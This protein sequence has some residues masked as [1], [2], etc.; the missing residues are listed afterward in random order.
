MATDTLSDVLRALRLRGSVFYCVSFGSEWSVGAPSMKE[1]AEA[2]LPGAE[3]VME[4]H[5]L[6]K[7]SGWASVVGGEPVR[8]SAG[9]I[10]MFPQGDPHVL[11][12]TPGLGGAATVDA[13]WLHEVRNEPKPIP[14]IFRTL[15][16]FSYGKPEPASP[17]NLACGYLGCDLRPF[18]PLISALPRML[19]LP[20]AGEGGW[21]S[22][23][24]LQAIDAYQNKRPGG[25]AV[26]ERISELMFVD[27]VRRY[28]ETLSD[29]SVGWLAGL[30]DRNIGKA[31]AVMHENPGK[32]WTVEMLADESALSRS[33]FYERFIGLIGSPPMQYLAQWRMQAAANLLRQSQASVASIALEVGYESEAA[34]ARAFKR[35]LGTPPATWR[36]SQN[37]R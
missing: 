37:K 36:R 10:V 31:L 7:G 4:Y 6:M 18:N 27:A 22:Q 12:S 17:I 26:L 2:V 34:F 25:D 16:E 14:I 33:A 24:M 9:D 30:R 15:T 11:S 1:I 3:H 19:H 5:V 28:V 8:V 20:A 23:V 21:V 13:K 32:P 29:S 35:E